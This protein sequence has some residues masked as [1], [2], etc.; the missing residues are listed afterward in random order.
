[1]PV[2]RRQRDFPEA[3]TEPSSAP[4]SVP[5]EALPNWVMSSVM[6]FLTPFFNGAGPA[7]YG[8]GPGF[9]YT[10]QA[11]RNFVQ[12]IE[13]NF[14]VTLP[15]GSGQHGARDALWRAIQTDRALLVKVLDYALNDVMLGY[16]AQGIDPAVKEL[17][18]SL[19]QAG[20]DYVVVQPSD[21]WVKFRLERRTTGAAAAAVRSQT[22]VPGNAAD[23]L[24]KAWAAAFGRE[25]NPSVA[26]SE[27]V[28]A[29]EAAAIPVVLPNDSLATLGK[30]VGE[31]R[32]D[33]QK[34]ATVFVRD[35]TP[36]KGTTLFPVEV[37]IALADQLWVNQT[38]RHAVGDPLPAVPI[39]QPQ[40]ELAVHNALTLVHTFRAALT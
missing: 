3:E 5:T 7:A 12:E 18:R 29:V 31:L 32:A 39:T 20:A 17:D 4:A 8:F 2:L 24:D 28:K 11:P 21:E 19:R 13:R 6:G 33:S 1:M 23:H 15:W 10:E 35:A 37:V 38:D 27:A 9:G 14:Q 26:Y 40:A 25:P 16:E 30:I 36:V 34:Y 22:S